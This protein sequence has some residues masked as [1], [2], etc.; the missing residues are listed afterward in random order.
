ML[1]WNNPLNHAPQETFQQSAWICV[2][3]HFFLELL[4]CI[5][6]GNQLNAEK[7]GGDEADMNKLRNIF[8]SILKDIKV[9]YGNTPQDTN[10]TEFQEML[11]EIKTK[12]AEVQKQHPI[13]EAEMA[14]I[15]ASMLYGS[16]VAELDET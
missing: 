1:F 4:S 13:T 2:V 12:S 14:S 10:Q 6:S 3:R 15:V 16:G 9:D 7:I 5:F 8:M 11:A